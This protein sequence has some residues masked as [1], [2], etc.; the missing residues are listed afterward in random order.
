MEILATKLTD[1]KLALVKEKLTPLAETYG[2]SFSDQ[3]GIHIK[4]GTHEYTFSVK[5][6]N[7]IVD[8]D[9]SITIRSTSYSLIFFKNINHFVPIIY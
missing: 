4:S 9:T 1:N 5:K 2:V 8:A 7:E 3:F 6:I